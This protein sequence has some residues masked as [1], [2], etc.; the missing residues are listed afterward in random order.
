MSFLPIPALVAWFALAGVFPSISQVPPDA[1]LDDSTLRLRIVQD[2]AITNA[3]CV[4][5][6]RDD[7][8]DGVVLYFVTASHL[9]KRTTG[10]APPRVTA[11]NVVVDGGHAISIHPDDLVLPV[12]SLV[13]IAILRAVVTHTTLVPQAVLFEPPVSGSVFLI[14][15]RDDAGALVALAERVRR[16]STAVIVGDRDASAVNGCEGAPAVDEAGVFGIVSECEAGRLPVVTLFSMA[17]NWI[18]RH[19]PGLSHQPSMKTQFTMFW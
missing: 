1:R 18:S 2:G 6:H 10:E 9:F 8:E 11:I 16:R 12:G 5:V 14:A 3:T 15:G 17:A 13:D 19:I 7:R 4:L